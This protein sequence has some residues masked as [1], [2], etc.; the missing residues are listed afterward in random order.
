VNVSGIVWPAPSSLG[1]RRAP[2]VK[3]NGRLG[4]VVDSGGSVV[5]DLICGFDK[6]S[7]DLGPLPN[8]MVL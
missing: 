7:A 5:Q 2:S 6:R 4:N 3:A 8:E 1:G